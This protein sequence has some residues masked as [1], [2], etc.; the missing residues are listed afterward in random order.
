RVAP[1]HLNK[2]LDYSALAGTK[3]F[4]PGA[5]N[6]SLS[7]PLD[8]A[9]TK[10]GATLYVAAFGSSRVGVFN[11]KALEDDSFNPVT[12]SANYIP[13]SW[14]GVSGLALDEKRSLLYVMTRFDDGVKVVNL[15][16]RQEVLGLALPN[17]EPNTI[18]E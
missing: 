14:G 6:H 11:T 3:Y 10:D 13:V 8:L 15:V 12:A 4:D 9:V 5:K 18:L 17:P 2:H 16:T 1:R 7:M